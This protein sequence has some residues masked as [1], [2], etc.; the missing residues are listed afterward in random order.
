[1]HLLE[2]VALLILTAVISISD[3]KATV[4]TWFSFFKALRCLIEFYLTR[5]SSTQ[6]ARVIQS[7]TPEVNARS[8]GNLQINYEIVHVNAARHKI[9]TQI[10]IRRSV[11]AN[12]DVS[13]SIQLDPSTDKFLPTAQ[14][15]NS[16]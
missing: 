15:Y 14:R 8:Q 4:S 1:M 11:M 6:Q 2:V 16:H 13:L 9:D 5:N 12:W 7:V 10:E 3:G